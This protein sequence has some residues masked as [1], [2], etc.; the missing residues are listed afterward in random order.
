MQKQYK[1]FKVVVESSE[2]LAAIEKELK[3]LG[4]KLDANFNSIKSPATCVTVWDDTTYDIWS[5]AVNPRNFQGHP[6]SYTLNDLCK[7]QELPYV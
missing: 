7:M 2:H 6:T 1:L 4:A 3:R 5:L